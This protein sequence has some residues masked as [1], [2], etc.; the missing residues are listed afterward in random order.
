MLHGQEGA[1][2]DKWKLPLPPAPLVPA[3]QRGRTGAHSTAPLFLKA[4][5]WPCNM[6][7]D[8]RELS[9]GMPEM[10]M[11]GA[12]Q[13]TGHNSPHAGSGGQPLLRRQRGTS[14]GAPRATCAAAAMPPAAAA[15]AIFAAALVLLLL[16]PCSCS[17]C[18]RPAAAA[19][20]MLAAAA[21][22]APLLLLLLL[23]LSPRCRSCCVDYSRRREARAAQLGH[24]GLQRRIR[25]RN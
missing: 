3:A 14:A 22:V 11:C 12:E 17:C 2:V 15:A 25:S 18:C 6:A 21:A 8:L 23:L 10:A 7:A 19:A 13:E 24:R 5:V 20:P 16:P 9:H 1:V 4:M